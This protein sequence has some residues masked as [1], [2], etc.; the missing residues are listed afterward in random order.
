MVR[1]AREK[2]NSG[3]Y[4]IMLRGINK[5]SIF[6]DD[7]DR[8]KLIEVLG[9]YKEISQCRIFAYCLMDNHLHILL[10]EI[11]ESSSVLIQRISSSYVIWY[12][13]KHER[14][15]H[16]FQER[17][18]SE[19]VDTD[20]YFLTVLRYIHQNPVKGKI[21]NDVADYKWSSYN[22]YIKGGR[23]ID[24]DAVLEMFSNK[25]TEAIKEFIQFIRTQN[26]DI[27]LEISEYKVTMSDEELRYRIQ[28]QLGIEAIKI[29]H[30]IKA[31]QDDILR[32]IKKVHG[33]NVR[34]ISRI[35]GLSA[36]RI[37]RA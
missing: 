29:C 11:Q 13:R 34:Q 7:E 25:R 32:I 8:F 2:S 30:E 18:K 23:I 17:F 21:V 37:W 26:D 14:C 20:R 9:K 12:N 28:S 1:T 5:Q 15:G 22:E 36:T 27:C 16:L 10:Q 31:K 4:H 35:T 6:E 3:I 19:P 24:K 33:T